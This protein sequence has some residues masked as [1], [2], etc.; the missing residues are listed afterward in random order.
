MIKCTVSK[1][2]LAEIARQN[3]RGVSNSY[4]EDHMRC[5]RKAVLNNLLG[6]RRG[7]GPATKFGDAV[8]AAIQKMVSVWG[9]TE[10]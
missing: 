7:V 3:F 5:P 9:R 6:Q 4:I 10:S 2:R 8:G 1:S